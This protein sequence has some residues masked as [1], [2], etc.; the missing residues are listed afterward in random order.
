MAGLQSKPLRRSVLHTVFQM[1]C[2][3][4][5]RPLSS[6][7]FKR[8]ILPWSDVGSCC[9]VKRYSFMV[10]PVP[11]RKVAPTL[12]QVV[13]GHFD[14]ARHSPIRRWRVPL[15]LILRPLAAA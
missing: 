13:V 3:T 7:L 10:E 11:R 5:T 12:T 2:P 4:K 6:Y 9:P 1:T 15:S 14:G 8:R